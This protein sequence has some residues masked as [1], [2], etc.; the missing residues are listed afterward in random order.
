[1]SNSFNKLLA[2]INRDNGTSFTDQQVSVTGA[3][4]NLDS[5]IARDSK[6]RVNAIKGE[7]FIGHVDAWY[8]RIDL[9]VLFKRINASVVYV[10]V[11]GDTT[12]ALIPALNARYGTDFEPSDFVS[13]PLV[14]SDQPQIVTLTATPGNVAYIGSFELTYAERSD[15][16]DSVVLITTL[17]GFNYPNTDLSK[18]QA[19][20]YSYNVVALNDDEPFLASIVPGPV[21]YQLVNA[22]NRAEEIEESWVF[23]TEAAEPCNMGG[24]VVFFNGLVANAPQGILINHSHESV[25][26]LQ[27]SE[28]CSNF[29]GILSIYYNPSTEPEPPIEYE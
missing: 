1:M 7:G 28:L 23:N 8:N 16:L 9:A 15:D 21:D 24:A 20:V 11:E 3:T 10:P 6:V 19:A 29:A 12:D 2:L 14:V 4:T 25:C 18:G 22:F 13:T 17:D 27:L 26:L 5:S